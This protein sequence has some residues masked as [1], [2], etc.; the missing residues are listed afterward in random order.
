MNANLEEIW[1]D[2]PKYEGFYQA[3]NLGNIRSLERWVNNRGN[4]QYVPFRVLKRTYQVYTGYECVSL[5]KDGISKR[6]YVHRVIME[7]FCGSGEGKYVDHKNEV[8]TDNRLENIRYCSN[9]DNAIFHFKPINKFTGTSKTRSNT[10]LAK[11]YFNGKRHGLG[12]RKTREKAHEL[13]EE[14]LHNINTYGSI[15]KGGEKINARPHEN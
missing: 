4:L 7:S 8:R 13:Y 9:R 1:K 10:W 15:I 12:T 3:S 2:V 14:A 6:V 11:I 5:T